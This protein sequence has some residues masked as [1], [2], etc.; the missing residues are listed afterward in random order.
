MQ[1]LVAHA[2]R[3]GELPA[4]FGR[5][6]A[7]GLYEPLIAVLGLDKARSS[8]ALRALA[9]TRPTYDAD[10]LNAVALQALRAG[11]R[12]A[13]YRYDLLIVPGYTPLKA[14]RP[15]RLA[16]LPA[17]RQRVELAAQEFLD[18]RAPYVFVTGGSVYPAGTP[19]NEALMMRE[20]LMEL[21]VSPSR[22]L[23]DPHA[24]HSTTNLRNAGRLMLELSLSR[25][26]IITGFESPVFSQGFYFGNPTL[27]TFTLRCRKE[28]GYCVGE[29]ISI[30]DNRIE[31]TPD[32]ACLTPS[33]DDPLDV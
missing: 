25:A 4:L 15:M 10:K 9:R 17:A 24:R 7:A 12:S 19:H 23:V 29:L 32:P 21:G 31:F 8:A 5:L 1:Q 3:R 22:I 26:L 11:S 30:D 16:D 2:E 33:Y 14:E 27:S 18:G 28:L 13:D 6:I 20:Y